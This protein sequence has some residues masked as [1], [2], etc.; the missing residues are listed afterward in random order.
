MK[1]GINS[2]NS[3]VNIFKDVADALNMEF[4]FKSKYRKDKTKIINEKLIRFIS[5]VTFAHNCI[6]IKK[7][8]NKKD[9][10]YGQRQYRFIHKQ[11]GFSLKRMYEKIPLFIQEYISKNLSKKN[12]ERL[13]GIISFE[14]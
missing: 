8:K 9:L 11:K 13:K 12:K 1:S 14:K 6:I 2:K 7:V 4:L 5:S 10:L 3:V